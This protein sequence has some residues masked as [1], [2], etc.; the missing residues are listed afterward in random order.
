MR[1]TDW[2]FWSALFAA[3]IFLGYSAAADQ[4][5][6]V[7]DPEATI[8]ACSRSIKSG[9]PKGRDL[10]AYYNN[11]AVA[12]RARGDN[13]RA[14]A[15]LN[16]AIRLDP[17]LA[18]AFNNRGA[19]YNEQGDNERA[20]AD[21]N[22]AIRLDPKFVMAFNNRGNAYSDQGDND[23]AIADYNETIRLDPKFARA[24]QNRGSAYHDKGD[25]DRAIAD[26][27]EAIRLEPKHAKAFLGRGIAFSAKGD[28][29]RA[30]TDFDAAIRLDPKSSLPYF[31]R[32]RSYLF[33]GSAEKALADLDQASAH[34]PDDVY[35]AL[36][37]E[38][39][40]Q[41]NNL[42]SRLAQTS[43]RIDMNVWPAPIIRL[44]MGQITPAAALAAADH[45]DASRKRGQV[46]EANFY[47]GELSLTKGLKDEATRLFRLA[48]S[49][50][51]RS[52]HE[53]EAA[54]AELTALGVVP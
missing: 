14:I 53:W 18:M 44:F 33:T 35:L 37:V 23:R 2:R 31:A 9:K 4:C 1:P 52:F 54:N 51:P 10:A 11:R 21:F 15:D 30:I 27:N 26:Y 45:R 42:P 22:E 8:T 38:I 5:D 36:W 28:N 47:S 32:G 40:S 46:C 16:E 17:K 3:T 48:A 41:R 25:N 24:F 19:A 49:D 34:A 29:D 6:S 39:A 43:S 50:C 7:Q 20:I 12:Y 13:H